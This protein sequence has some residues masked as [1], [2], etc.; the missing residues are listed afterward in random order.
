MGRIFMCSLLSAA[1]VLCH[2]GVATAR[3]ASKA[4]GRGATPAT[5][6]SAATLSQCELEELKA[7]LKPPKGEKRE[8]I[9]PRRK[10]SPPPAQSSQKPEGQ[11]EEHGEET[12][13]KAE[14][15][16]A[17]SPDGASFNQ[18]LAFVAENQYDSAIGAFTLALA[19]NRRDASSY[20][21]RA[22][23]H[24]RAGKYGAAVEDYTK[25]AGITP[26]DAD[27]YYNRGLAYQ[28]SGNARQAIEDYGR[29]IQLN[30]GDPWPHWNRGIALSREGRIDLAT[31]DFCSSIDLSSSHGP[32]RK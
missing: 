12:G 32:S 16:K 22:L 23:L 8:A 30:P 15:N 27:L 7:A 31:T 3:H 13:K 1:L 11:T 18:G 5:L 21:N 28:C 6:A 25:A 14:A 9:L 24:Q 17:H 20:Y 19:S 10:A 4:K 2:G 29:A 26:N